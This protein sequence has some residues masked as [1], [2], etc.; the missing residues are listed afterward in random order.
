MYMQPAVAALR[1]RRRQYFQRPTV[2]QHVT[3]HAETRDDYGR[4]GVDAVGARCRLPKHISLKIT[5]ALSQVSDCGPCEQQQYSLETPRQL[6][7]YR[8]DTRQRS[9]FTMQIQGFFAR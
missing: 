8:C 1:H 5:T 7:D 6:D 3:P 4:C 9:L 2:A